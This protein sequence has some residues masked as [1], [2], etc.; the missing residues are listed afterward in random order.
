MLVMLVFDAKSDDVNQRTGYERLQ[1][2][3]SASLRHSDHGFADEVSRRGRGDNAN[4]QSNRNGCTEVWSNGPPQRHA[5]RYAVQ[6]N[7]VCEAA[8][9]FR[10]NCDAVDDRVQDDSERGNCHDNQVSGIGCASKQALKDKR[11][12]DAQNDHHHGGK[13]TVFQSHRNYVETDDRRNGK[14]DYA[15]YDTTSNR[16]IAAHPTQNRADK[17]SGSAQDQRYHFGWVLSVGRMGP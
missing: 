14:N 11:E 16:M 15:I 3:D 8:A 10:Q 7:R 2:S 1:K 13:P 12:R 9:A 4:E 5:D 6:Y 17:Q